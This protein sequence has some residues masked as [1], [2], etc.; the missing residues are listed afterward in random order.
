MSTLPLSE[1]TAPSR[2]I[3]ANICGMSPSTTGVRGC[4]TEMRVFVLKTPH[5]DSRK[6]AA[7]RQ[8]ARRS[9]TH[10]EAFGL[11][12]GKGRPRHYHRISQGKLTNA[13]PPCQRGERF[14]VLGT[15]FWV[16][17]VLGAAA[18]D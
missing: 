2:F 1:R 9:D 7:R 16:L 18:G 11:C 12:I 6:A 4:G 14:W 17:R 10:F 13:V 8:A 5:P 15:G 3:S